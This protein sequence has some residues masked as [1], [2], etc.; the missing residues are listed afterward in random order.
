MITESSPP[1]FV[2]GVP[3]SGT[4]L[5]ASMLS[6]HSRLACGPETQFFNKLST[7]DLRR[8]TRADAWPDQAVELL[9]RLTLARQPVYELFGHE[10]EE[11]R[12]FL[13]QRP[14][15]PRSMLE[16]LTK[17]HAHKLA[18]P[19]WVEKTPNHLLHLGQVRA[20]FPDSPVIRIVRDPRDAALSMCSLPWASQSTLANAYLW[21][22]CHTASRDFFATDECTFTLR[23]EDLVAAP[24]RVLD[25]ACRFL[26]ELFEEGMLD[27]WALGEGVSSPNETWK[28]TNVQTLDAT[29][30]ERWRHELSEPLR[31]AVT[32]ACLDGIEDFGYPPAPAPA[33]TVHV[34]PTDRRTVEL[35]EPYLVE[36]A[37]YGVGATP[38]GS[39]WRPGELWLLAAP[40][41]SWLGRAVEL[42]L[43]S[44]VRLLRLVGRRR[45][46]YVSRRSAASLRRRLDRPT[47]HEG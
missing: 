30:A 33:R 5:L 32:S 23:Y 21:T 47:T 44:G 18:K 37:G 36:C 3:R 27:T 17:L 19:R 12:S 25:E 24:S 11:L 45:T 16:S 10:L 13:S 9:S 20:L 43:L 42:V 26:G 1:V 28:R 4:T 29:R 6:G 31:D 2:V 41:N 22:Y 38:A 34:F 7:R 14:A 8:V 46:S 35:H 15:N 39:L 40:R